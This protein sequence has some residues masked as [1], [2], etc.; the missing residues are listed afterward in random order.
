MRLRAC[1]SFCNCQDHSERSNFQ[2]ET[3]RKGGK[4]VDPEK[5]VDQQPSCGKKGFDREPASRRRRR[6]ESKL[7]H[8]A[9][10]EEQEGAD[11]EGI[12]EYGLQE[13]VRVRASKIRGRWPRLRQTAASFSFS[14]GFVPQVLFT[15]SCGRRNRV[16]ASRR[17]RP[18][19]G[20]LSGSWQFLTC[21]PGVGHRHSAPAP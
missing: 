4:Y 17:G 20:A 11:H 10:D 18:A 19:F 13:K 7:A 21:R 15:R 16:S 6:A 5:V 12:Q 8:G 14:R 3:P 1:R 2:H 9:V